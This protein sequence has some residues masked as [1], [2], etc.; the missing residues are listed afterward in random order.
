M[1]KDK[2]G[3]M[4]SLDFSEE[5]ELKIKVKSG[6]FKAMY[7]LGKIY[8]DRGKIEEAMKSYFDSC[9][10]NAIALEHLTEFIHL[11][12]DVYKKITMNYKNS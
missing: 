8:E 9:Q 6:D 3:Q 5:Y 7:Y 1:I 4:S 2:T 10:G 11:H 12:Q